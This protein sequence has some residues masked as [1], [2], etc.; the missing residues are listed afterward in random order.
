MI[1][2]ICPVC[3]QVMKSVHY[4]SNCRSWVKHPHV[5]EMNFYLNERHPENEE[6]CSYHSGENQ[7]KEGAAGQPVQPGGAWRP[8]GAPL[9][10]R[11]PLPSK[12]SFPPRT[13]LPS[14][15]FSYHR[16][17]TGEGKAGKG[18][19]G[20]RAILGIVLA[21]AFVSILPAFFNVMQKTMY[22]V[23]MPAMEYD[24]DLGDYSGEET[25]NIYQELEEEDVAARGEA[26]NSR[27]HFAVD[28]KRL[29][30]PILEI[31]KGAGYQVKRQD[32]YSYNEAFPDGETWF[33]TWIT[34]EVE[35]HGESGYQYVELNSDTGT[36]K[37]HEVSLSLDDPGYLTEVTCA[38]LRTLVQEGE[39]SENAECI[40]LVEKE[41]P[42]ALASG[43]GYSLLEG[44]VQ[45]EGISYEDSY[46]VY[47]SHN[48]D[49][50]L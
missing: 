15:D 7:K 20:S 23:V 33:T 22:S 2:R 13:P 21:A 19:S 17:K 29:E 37:L 32:T 12:T 50:D 25:D 41:L 11:T 35:G 36:G 31:L 45:I 26:C 30:D 24:I 42:G 34:I 10:S 47:I 1:Q 9:P 38:I 49:S 28:G 18:R 3:D 5:M 39:L 16:D 6:G 40:T 48:I 46:F 44:A 4:C 8:A 27:G 43:S 14:G